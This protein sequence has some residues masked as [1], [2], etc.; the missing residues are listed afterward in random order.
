MRWAG[1]IARMR[2]RRGAYRFLVGKP[3]DEGQLGRLKS[4][5]EGV[6]KIDWFKIG[7]GAGFFCEC[8]N[9]P[10]GSLKYKIFFLMFSITCIYLRYGFEI[11]DI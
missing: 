9:E 4:R 7:T 2:E 5:W 11:Y 1:H 3:K 6:I 8:G 10:S